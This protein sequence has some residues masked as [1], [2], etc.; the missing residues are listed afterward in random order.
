MSGSPHL[1]HHCAAGMLWVSPRALFWGRK[2]QSA[3][4]LKRSDVDSEKVG[5]VPGTAV[6]VWTGSL[7]EEGLVPG[8]RE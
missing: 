7:E 3:V 5:Q 4:F 2:P 6:Q 1:L 8:C